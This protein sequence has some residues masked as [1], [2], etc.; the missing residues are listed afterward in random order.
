MKLQL[1]RRM[2]T[3]FHTG[4][5]QSCCYLALKKNLIYSE[6]ICVFMYSYLSRLGVI[7]RHKLKHSLAAV[8]R[9]MVLLK[10]E[11]IK[12]DE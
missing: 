11:N 5:I 8:P 3:T 7:Y 10:F 9:K 1:G 12:K 4:R 2:Y 6:Y